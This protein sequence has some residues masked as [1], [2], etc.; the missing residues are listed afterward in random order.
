MTIAFGVGYTDQR[1]GTSRTPSANQGNKAGGVYHSALY[2]GHTGQ[3]STAARWRSRLIGLI[4]SFSA[5]FLSE[6]TP[7]MLTLSIDALRDGH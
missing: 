5:L 3:S 4:E 2:N 1:G 7:V 6:L